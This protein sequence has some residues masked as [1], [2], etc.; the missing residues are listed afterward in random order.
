MYVRLLYTNFLDPV[1]VASG[2]TI[3]VENCEN[4]IRYHITL[5]MGWGNGLAK[6]KEALRARFAAMLPD[7]YDQQPFICVQ[8]RQLTGIS[9]LAKVVYFVY[10]SYC[11]TNV[12]T[13][14]WSPGSA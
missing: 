3:R 1:T 12:V 11:T 6:W 7:I 5:L 9:K 4:M 10:Y 14:I 8:N 13:L 2:G